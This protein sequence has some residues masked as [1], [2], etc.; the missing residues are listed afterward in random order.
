[1]KEF[2]IARAL[3]DVSDD[4]LL[5]AENAGA[6]RKTVKLHRLVAVAA[7][8]A[9]LTVTVGAVKYGI[10]YRHGRENAGE[11]GWH[12]LAFE[13]PLAPVT[14]RQEAYDELTEAL[15]A[16][17]SENWS[18][19]D[20]WQQNQPELHYRGIAEQVEERICTI[21]ELEEY[22]GLDLI[23]SPEID[24]SARLKWEENQA[25]GNGT[26]ILI[27]PCADMIKYAAQEYTETGGVSL[28]GVV[29][30]VYLGE[31]GTNAYAGL[32]ICIPLTER[33]AQ[34]YPAEVW[35]SEP[36]VGDYEVEALQI[37]GR[38]VLVCTQPTD[39][40]T[41]TPTALALYSGD[42]ICYYVYASAEP[43]RHWL[44]EPDVMLGH[45]KE[46]LIPLIENLE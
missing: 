30:W 1:M 35:Y 7:I 14:I 22:L 25:K 11:T 41:K 16:D 33:F 20:G 31:S 42:G 3:T 9:M 39:D 36:E 24:E 38:E 46:R 23:T 6:P 26:S 8:I 10:E 34:T 40:L 13:Y 28:Q 32:R 37:T 4:L 2:E 45:G 19:E 43:L 21:G 17:W 15:N 44:D 27:F 18:N 12:T 29:I 5:E